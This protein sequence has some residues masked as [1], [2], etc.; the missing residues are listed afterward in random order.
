MDDANNEL[1]AAISADLM[2]VVTNR[3]FFERLDDRLCP[4][5]ES[6]S[7]EQCKG[8]YKISET[9]LRSLGFDDDELQD[10]FQVFQSK[11]GFCDCEILFNVSET[12][13]LKAKYWRER[14]TDSNTHIKHH[15]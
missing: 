7:P 8:K 5:T 14:A 3:G 9:L 13:R 11:G 12:N 10:I 1:I 4:L 2:R 6:E 15:F